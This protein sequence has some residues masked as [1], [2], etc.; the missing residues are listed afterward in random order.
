MKRNLFAD[1]LISAQAVGRVDPASPA[2]IV[3]LAFH[4]DQRGG[5]GGARAHV[6]AAHPPVAARQANS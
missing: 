6:F 1:L 4:G 5:L 3:P 2:D